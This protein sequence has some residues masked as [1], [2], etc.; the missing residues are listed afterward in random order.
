MKICQD[1]Q[2]EGHGDGLKQGYQLLL[3]LH[4]GKAHVERTR[5]KTGPSSLHWSMMTLPPYRE[6]EEAHHP[7]TPDNFFSELG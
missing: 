3:P 1:T 7:I 4:V 5:R 6:E 2:L